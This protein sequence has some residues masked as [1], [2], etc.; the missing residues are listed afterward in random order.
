MSYIKSYRGQNY[1]LPPNLAD[2][3]SKNHVCYLIEHIAD[4]M[5]YNEFDIK[6]AG[7]GHP[8]YHPRIAL[9]LLAMANVDSNRSSRKIAKNA[10]ENVVYIY[11]SEKVS[12]NFRTISDFRKNNSE[13]IK[14]FMLELNQFA[15]ENGLIDLS[16]LMVDGTTIKANANNNR[17]LDKAII[18]KLE[19]YI[20]K[21]IQRGI[22]IDDEEDKIYG[23][24]GYNELPDDFNTSEKRRPIVKKIVDRINKSIKKDN[25][26][27]V[28]EELKK[29]KK[30]M[31]DESLK[32]YSVTDPESR[33]MLGKKGKVELN[34]N[35]QLV[36][37][38]N[39]IIISNDVVQDCED[40][41]QLLPG[42]NRVEKDFNILPKKTTVCTDG[43]YM[44]KDITELDKKGYNLL[45]P[46]YGMQKSKIEKFDTLNFKYNEN[47][48][49]YICPEGKSLNFLRKNKDKK[50]EYTLMYKCSDCT[51]CPDQLACCKKNKYKTILALP[52][53]KLVNRIKDKM[54]SPEGRAIYKLREQT[55]ERS[56]GDIKHNKKFRDFLLRG[57]D[58]V[59]IEFNLACIGHNL[60]MINNLLKKKD[61][62]IVE[63]C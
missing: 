63:S 13:L 54:Q 31:D 43:L 6:Y 35:A 5:N 29:I 46:T 21:E 8:A 12:P 33:F 50:Y 3:F 44:S 56:F 11:L 24:R 49:H 22:D 48:D 28:K 2:L 32:K 16:H 7:S 51:T 14:A 52:H 59:K 47:K 60:V 42:I 34:Y 62:S 17:V 37:D 39:G 25:A 4:S 10:Q 45:M 57:V 1:L 55:V 26:K 53:S 27:K 20:D 40:R 23:D 18:K 38:K 61:I 19:K 15:H 58:K 30:N 36:T 41:H 9:K